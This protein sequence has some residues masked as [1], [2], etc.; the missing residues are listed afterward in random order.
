MD[1]YKR[2]VEIPDGRDWLW[3]R[4]SYLALLGRAKLSKTLIQFSANGWGS[5]PSLGV[6]WPEATQS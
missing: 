4:K 1:V 3:G 6:V 2:L 5:T